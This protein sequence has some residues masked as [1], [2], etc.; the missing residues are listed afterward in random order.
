MVAAIDRYA[1]VLERT[2]G[3]PNAVAALERW[4]R[5]DAE[6]YRVAVILEPVY[7]RSGDLG[8]LVGA[9]DAQLETV[10]DRDEQRAASCAR[11]R[12]FISASAARTWRSTAAAA[13]G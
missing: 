1:E 7:R 12:R 9:L 5:T 11:W 4:R 8:K 3:Q 13:P 6:R 10:D 2:P